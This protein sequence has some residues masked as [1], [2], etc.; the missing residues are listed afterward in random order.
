[1]LNVL[2]SRKAGALTAIAATI[3]LTG[4][5]VVGAVAR[6]RLRTRPAPSPRRTDKGQWP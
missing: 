5:A 4:A 2:K 1:M 3:A 6:P